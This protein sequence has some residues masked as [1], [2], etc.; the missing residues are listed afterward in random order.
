MEHRGQI[1]VANIFDA[2]DDAYY[3][4]MAKIETGA[5]SKKECY[6]AYR[7]DAEKLKGNIVIRLENPFEEISNLNLDGA[8]TSNF[9][10]STPP[11][12]FESASS[13]EVILYGMW[14]LMMRD[15]INAP[16]ISKIKN[17]Y[18]VGIIQSVLH[19]EYE[20]EYFGGKSQRML[21]PYRLHGIDSE[22]MR[23]MYTPQILNVG[24]ALN[25]YLRRIN[26]L[27]LSHT[28]PR[29]ITIDEECLEEKV[30]DEL[31]KTKLI[32][33]EMEPQQ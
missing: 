21:V 32:L 24:N 11:K 19:F 8:V 15:G 4:Y 3:K 7:G 20:H 23:S 28:T 29:V 5:L 2:V 12:G 6:V 26:K 1:V 14:R 27:P 25:R 18:D 16:V 33:I 10:T 13:D 22:K 9:V 17:Y 31:A 30:L